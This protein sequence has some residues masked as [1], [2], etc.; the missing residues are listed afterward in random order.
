[1]RGVVNKYA[2]YVSQWSHFI[3]N[4]SSPTAKILGHREKLFIFAM[5]VGYCT[6]KHS[7]FLSGQISLLYSEIT[8]FVIYEFKAC[9]GYKNY[10]D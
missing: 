6:Y 3:N 7:V 8:S 9:A 1:M 5:S 2:L 10:S 4:K